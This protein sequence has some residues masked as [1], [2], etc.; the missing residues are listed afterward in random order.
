MGY[1]TISLSNEAYN[2][3]KTKKLKGESFNDLILRLL[4]EPEQ[5]DILKL[6]GSWKGST[7]EVENILDLIY[8]N[9]EEAR[10]PR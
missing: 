6:K 1:K 10:I 3:L 2:V 8:K 5:K 4:S 7:E 9:R